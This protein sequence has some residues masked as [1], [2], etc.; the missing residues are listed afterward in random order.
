M[1][2]V[3]SIPQEVLSYQP[4][5][6]VVALEIEGPRSGHLSIKLPGEPPA[7]FPTLINHP[8]AVQRRHEQL[9]SCQDALANCFTQR[10][11]Q[12]NPGQQAEMEDLWE[13]LLSAG[14]AAYHNLFS[15]PNAASF[16]VECLETVPEG[17]FPF[18]AINCDHAMFPWELLIDR[19]GEDAK[20]N[21]WGAKYCL[22][23]QASRVGDVPCKPLRIPGNSLLQV[24]MLPDNTL[25]RV[26]DE[27]VFLSRFDGICFHLLGS[28]TVGAYIENIQQVQ[29]FLSRDHD[30]LH[31]ACHAQAG[32]LYA[33]QIYITLTGDCQMVASCQIDLADLDQGGILLFNG[34][35]LIVMNACFTGVH[36]A[37]P[38]PFGIVTDFIGRRAGG[39]VATETSVPDTGAAEFTKQFYEKFVRERKSLGIVVME[40]RRHFLS[41]DNPL[42]FSYA[43]YADPF[44]QVV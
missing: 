26:N 27:I 40:I 6:I 31:F 8:E 36:R 1:F 37:A 34:R 30:L 20:S 17:E 39:V 16:F 12:V 29:A 19:I 24:G 21:L 32:D 3:L 41:Q 13:K 38:S 7:Y 28:L 44:G 18:I 43:L 23:R 22:F 15:D 10:W 35:V 9:L 5:H 42:G 4:P 25:S 11:D 2:R 14:N 33:D